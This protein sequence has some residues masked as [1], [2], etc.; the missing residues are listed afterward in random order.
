MKVEILGAY[1]GQSDT[2]FLTCFLIDDFL[3]VDAGCLTQTLNLER[4]ARISDVLISHTHLDHTLSLPFMVDN[5][6]GQTK[7]PLRVWSHQAVIDGLTRHIF[8]E[9]TWPDFA[10]LPSPEE[11]SITF[12]VL[13]NEVTFAIKHLHITPVFV[14]HVVPTFAYLV[15]CTRS[16]AAILFSSD[17]SNT[18][19]IWEAANRQQNLKAIVVDCSFP[20]D[21]EDLA[22]IS[23]HMTPDMLGRD[24][25]K[26]TNDCEILIYHIKP[27]FE[28][29]I[30]EQLTALNH[31]RMTTS[32]QGRIFHF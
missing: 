31:P 4:Q 30:M 3:A 16:N 10:V 18:G 11:P 1:G 8:N 21:M 5:L 25:K 27:M 15:E 6:F 19:R 20:N 23:G 7:E 13:K 12:S 2:S 26:L 29:E 17:T 14:N 9:V 32:I 22:V 24:L 28:D